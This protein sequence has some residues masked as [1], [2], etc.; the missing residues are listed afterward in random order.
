[1]FH[2]DNIVIVCYPSGAGGKFLINSLALSNQCYLQ[3]IELVRQQ[4]RGALSPQDKYNVLSRELDLVNGVWQDGAYQPG[5]WNDLRMGCQKLFNDQFDPGTFDPLIQEI[6]QESQRFFVVAHGDKM[7]ARLHSIW[8]C[9]RIIQFVHMNSF[10]Q[11]RAGWQEKSTQ[12]SDAL[13]GHNTIK[14]DA[15]YY[16]DHDT[17]I[18]RLRDLY[19]QLELTD[20]N[21]TLVSNFYSK[22]MST[23]KKL[24][25]HDNN[26]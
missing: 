15:D 10:L 26:N 16:M 6:A 11:W 9:A 20:F 7:F 1:M 4:R 24:I 22:Y 21:E 18:A 14:W 2:N 12:L 8:P 25:K 19:Q 5:T 13:A 17:F 23:I 3:D